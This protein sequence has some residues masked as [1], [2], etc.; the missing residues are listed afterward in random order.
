MTPEQFREYGHQVIDWIAD[1]HERVESLPVLSQAEP[2]DLRAALPAHPPEQGERFDAGARRP[3]RADPARHHALAA[4]VVLRLLP[5]QRE[6]PVHSRRPAR[7]R[8]RRA[9][10][11]LVD[12]AGGHRARDPR[13]GLAARDA[14]PARAASARTGRAAASSSTRP[15]TPRWSPCS[16]RCTAPAAERPNATASASARFTVYTSSQTHSS[17]EKACRI[18]GLG[19]AALRKL[20]VD[21]ADHGGAARTPARADRGRRRGRPDPGAGRRVGR[22]HRHRRDRSDPRARRDRARVR[23]L[24]A[25]RRRLGRRRARSARSC[26]GSTTAPS[27]PTPTAP[28]RTSGC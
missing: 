1:Y 21:P 11:A 27:W 20:D 6:R 13:P 16:P 19:S 28:T 8:T 5:G 15:P 24:A 14:R 10:H 3:R 7:V 22:R 26:G 12:L 2:G 23:R 17:V 18:A 9:G 25:R 4:P